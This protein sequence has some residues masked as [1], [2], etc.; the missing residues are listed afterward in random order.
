MALPLS[1]DDKRVLRLLRESG[2]LTMSEI[3]TTLDMEISETAMALARLTRRGLV[4]VRNF[5]E[6][7]DIG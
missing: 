6:A 5:Y 7:T 1:E 2:G 3:A 4:T